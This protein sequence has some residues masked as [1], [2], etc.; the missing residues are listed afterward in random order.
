MR[1]EWWVKTIALGLMLLVAVSMAHAEPL[2]VAVDDQVASVKAGDSTRIRYRFADAPFKPYLAELYSPKGIQI[3]RDSPS[4]HKHHHALMF[5]VTVDG[6]NFWEEATSPGVQV[7][8]RFEDVGTAIQGGVERAGFTERLDWTAP[9]GQSVLLKETRRIDLFQIADVD[10]SVVGWRARLEVPEGKPSATL[11]GAHYHGLGMRFLTSMDGVGRFFHAAG[12]AG[13][14]VR[15]DERLTPADW[16]A[17]IAEA[18]GKPATVAVF[19]HPDNLR[20]PAL[21]FTMGTPF[22]YISATMNLWREPLEIATGKPLDLHYGVAL[23]D[24]EIPA[25]EIQALYDRWVALP[26]AFPAVP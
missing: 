13:E 14:V 10:A 21:W 1:E 2:R 4:D 9:D 23:W 24:G 26:G 25:E 8:G 5:A 6:V 3:L 20:R 11:T 22:S 12:G 19:D 18:D 17:F 15:G 7:H 16:C